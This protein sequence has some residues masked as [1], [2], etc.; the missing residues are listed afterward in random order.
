MF[1]AELTISD[2]GKLPSSARE[3]QNI[4]S[5][6]LKRGLW[7]PPRTDNPSF[8]VG[9]LNTITLNNS[10][11][12]HQEEIFTGRVR[13]PDKYSQIT[14]LQA[15][16]Q[17]VRDADREPTEAELIEA[18]ADDIGLDARLINLI[19]RQSQAG[20][21][22]ADQS[23]NFQK[24]LQKSVN[25][26]FKEEAKYRVPMELDEGLPS[27]FELSTRQGIKKLER[28]ALKPFDKFR[29]EI[30]DLAKKG[31]ATA[32][33]IATVARA[34]GYPQYADAAEGIAG[35]I[36]RGQRLERLFSSI[37]QNPEQSLTEEFLRNLG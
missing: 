30:K 24:T 8:A 31:K 7:L 18:R 20:N 37:E 25:S 15:Y 5:H 23:Q 27:L 35:F 16:I 9:D 26:Y 1:D 3:W 17:L 22:Y 13:K 29:S 6:E 12:A 14:D 19:N 21:Y 32:S 11:I 36:S 28:K 10:G 33:A 34:L 4:K 2:L